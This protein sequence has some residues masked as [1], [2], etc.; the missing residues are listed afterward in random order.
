[1]GRGTGIKSEIICLHHTVK[2]AR[3]RTHISLTTTVVG[4][5]DGVFL[6]GHI[7]RPPPETVQGVQGTLKLG[8]D[9]SVRKQNVKV[10]WGFCK[11]RAKDQ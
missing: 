3:I 6:S 1:M 10:F 8:Q 2:R 11:A 4:M 5:G 7:G 9:V